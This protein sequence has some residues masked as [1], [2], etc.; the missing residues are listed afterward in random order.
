MVTRIT[1]CISQLVPG[2]PGLR[3]DAVGG[4]VT[5]A[6]VAVGP[7]A[8][9]VLEGASSSHR[10]RRQQ[11]LR[12][13]LQRPHHDYLPWALCMRASPASRQKDFPYPLHGGGDRCCL[14]L[15]LGSVRFVQPQVRHRRS[16]RPLHQHNRLWV[17]T[18]RS[19]PSKQVSS[20]SY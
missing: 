4:H 17:Q 7:G 1:C 18:R 9:S 10:R 20:H 12:G 13:H 11:G 3:G 6:A 5:Q 19:L 15:R 14:R 2:R 8:G 16:H